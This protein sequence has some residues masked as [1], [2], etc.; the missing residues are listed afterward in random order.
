[1]HGVP[2]IAYGRGAIGEIVSSVC[3]LVIDPSQDFVS[4]AVA[5][6]QVWRESPQ[7]L[8]HA[9]EGARDRFLAVCLENKKRWE[10]VR[11]ELCG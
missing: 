1:M 7:A 6:L 3:G 8:Q 2:V 11:A 5:Q 4:H 10:S 9:S